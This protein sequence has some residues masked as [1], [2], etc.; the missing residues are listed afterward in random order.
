MSLKVI[1]V[2]RDGCP[3]CESFKPVYND[4]IN[5]LDNL[6]DKIKYNLS[7]HIFDTEKD[8]SQIINHQLLNIKGVPS[9]YLTYFNKNGQQKIINEITDRGSNLSEFTN[10]LIKTFQNMKIQ[11]GGS[12]HSLDPYFNK[13]L[14]YK[15]KYLSLKNNSF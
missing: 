14:K 12:N 2:K 11:D 8:K 10:N 15:N 6:K 4:F 3:H 1:L 7:A 13:Y 5:N 9:I